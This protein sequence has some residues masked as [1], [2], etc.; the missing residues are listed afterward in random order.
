MKPVSQYRYLVDLPS[1]NDFDATAME[2]LQNFHQF[3]RSIEVSYSL[4]FN[5]GSDMW[6][7]VTSSPAQAE[8][9]TTKDGSLSISISRVYDYFLN[10]DFI[11]DAPAAIMPYLKINEQY[12][13]PSN[14]SN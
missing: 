12:K 6:Y 14:E 4:V 7:V 3:M 1:F 5:D 9:I 10:N 13:E 11:I 2:H 8:C